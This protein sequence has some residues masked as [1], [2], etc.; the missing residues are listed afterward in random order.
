MT[1]TVI[2]RYSTIVDV[3]KYQIV[4]DLIKNYEL[5]NYLEEKSNRIAVVSVAN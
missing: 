2:V 4:C 5:K 3:I 1:I